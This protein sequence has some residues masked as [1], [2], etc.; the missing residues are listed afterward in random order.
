MSVLSDILNL[1]SGP[2]GGMAYHLI[3]LFCIWAIVGLALSRLSHDDHAHISQRILLAGSLLS[4][5]RF[6][7]IVVALLDRMNGVSLV[8]LGPPLERFVDTLSALLICA[9]FVLPR[10][11]KT[12]NR[13]LVGMLAAFSLGL[14]VIAALQWD[15]L[16]RTLPAAIYNRATQ[17]WIW[18]LWQLTLLV[19]AFAYVLLGPV[20]EREALGA[21]LGVLIVTHLAQVI[22]PAASQIP[23]A[24]GW[25]RLGNLVAFPLLGV[26]TY[27][28]FFQRFETEAAE[29]QR[30]NEQSLAQITNLMS[31][32]EASTRLSRSLDLNH[33][34]SNALVVIAQEMQSDLC[35]LALVPAQTT[36]AGT[37]QADALDLTAVFDTPDVF[38]E[39][40]R[41]SLHNYPTIRHAVTQNRPVT[42]GARGPAGY[43][44]SA[45]QD[46]TAS[47]FKLLSSD[48][49]GVLIVQ[50]IEANPQAVAAQGTNGLESTP[51]VGVLLIGR[52]DPSRTFTSDDM[53]KS[54][55]LAAYLGT[56]IENARRYNLAQAQIDQLAASRQALETE[57]IRTKTDLENRLQES[58][59]QTTAFMQRLYEAERGEQQAQ[60][61]AHQVHREMA[62]LRQES[63]QELVQA[64]NE[65]MRGIQHAARLTQH[66]AELDAE[67][68]R[69]DSLV[70]TL[71]IERDTQ[72]L[73]LAV[74]ANDQSTLQPIPTHV[75]H[76]IQQA[77]NNV[78]FRLEARQLRTS[79]AI[80]ADPIA[81]ID[82]VIVQHILTNLLDALCGFAQAGTTID[83]QVSIDWD[84]VSTDTTLADLH[85]TLTGNAEPE[86]D[87]TIC[88]TSTGENSVV[89]ALAQTHGGRV[90]CEHRPDGVAF[91]LAL[92]LR[93]AGDRT[94][95]DT[96]TG[97][98]RG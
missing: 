37:T 47:V 61:D 34:L 7:L 45:S 17:R 22:Y 92:P 63:Q 29:L 14:Y 4:L 72:E 93:Q 70:K 40:T 65:I 9:A 2:T 43:N 68:L 25:V 30:V 78:R 13:L 80:G 88:D 33:V 42:L 77:L 6:L 79:L 32:L 57:H 8:R 35:A 44:G 96:R 38:Q 94:A 85:I 90:W 12:A 86:G 82:P 87:R 54:E 95:D 19:P 56:A 39:G 18:E 16:L 20:E 26:S 74:T 41:F 69:L 24:A 48:R 10:Q 15:S 27:L 52:T 73:R 36:P 76:P 75:T 5:C 67:R 97:D 51:V 46:E 53:H 91:H 58:K 81:L 23:H 50:P 28:L 21:S 62:R 89:Q 60:K 3:L 83:V 31:M 1:L 98:Q 66:I 84:Q 55:S 11:K 49:R 64:R 71:Q 59:A